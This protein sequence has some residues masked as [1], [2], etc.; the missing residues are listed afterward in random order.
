MCDASNSALRAILG[1]RVSKQ[2]LVI[3]YASRTM[4]PAQMNY[5]TTEK[6]LLAIVFALDK[7]RS[8]LLRSKIII[9]S[10]HTALKFLLKKPDEFDLEIRDKKAKLREESTSLP[11]RD[12]FPDKQLL[13]IDKSEPWFV[14]IC[15]FLIATMFPPAASKS[16]KDKIESDAKYYIWDDLDSTM[17]KS[18]VSA[19][20]IPR[21]SRFFIFVIQHLMAA[22]MDQVRWLKKYSTV[23]SIGPQ[24]FE[25]LTN[26]SRPTNSVSEQEWPSTKGMKC[27]NSRFCFVKFLT[28][29]VLIS[30]GHSPSPMEILIF[31]LSLT[32]CRDGRRL[33]PPRLM[34]LKFGVSKALITD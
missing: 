5:T 2:L 9:F 27:P 18:F 30:W 17:T 7:F 3:A 31:S 19:F 20:R 4:D 29:R 32:M 28:C 26:M 24:F 11:I 23:G 1:Q 6:E 34:M 13:Q 16:Y 8:Y 21:S 12:D 15:N 14:D 25:M 22:I 10:K 33:K